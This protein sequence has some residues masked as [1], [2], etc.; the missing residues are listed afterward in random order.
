VKAIKTLGLAVAAAMATMAILGA[1]SASAAEEALCKEANLTPC[2][3]EK[4]YTL[5]QTIKWK[6]SSPQGVFSERTAIKKSSENQS[7]VKNLKVKEPQ[8]KRKQNKSSAKSRKRRK[9][10]AKAHLAKPA[11]SQHSNFHGERI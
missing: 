2:P 1:G 5:P 3:A 7:A 9:K 4:Q 10:N 8:A 6:L 11:H